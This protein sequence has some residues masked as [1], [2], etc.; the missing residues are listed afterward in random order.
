LVATIASSP[1][2]GVTPPDGARSGPAAYSLQTADTAHAGATPSADPS[3]GTGFG[4]AG[5]APSGAGRP[6]G[7][8]GGSAA[9]GLPNGSTPDAALTK[10]IGTDASRYTPVPGE[11]GREATMPPGSPPG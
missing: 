2:T 4:R 9:G 10:L 8:P 1:A 11:R 5:S 6:G 3:V 7:G